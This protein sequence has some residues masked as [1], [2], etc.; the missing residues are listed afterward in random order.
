MFL[1]NPHGVVFGEDASVDTAGLV[2]STLGISDAD[3][4]AGNYRFEAGPDAGKVTNQ[5]S[6]EAGAGGVFLLAPNVENSGVIQ[7]DGGDLV[8][9]AGRAITLT[10]L[11]L[12][13]IQV[14]VQAPED[15]AVNLGTLLAERGAAG[16]FAGSIRNAGTVE[17][18]AVTLAEDGTVR[19]VFQDGLAL[20]AEER[21][22]A[23]VPASTT[24]NAGTV[25]LVAQGDLTLEAGGRV[26][27]DGL[28][29]RAGAR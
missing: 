7:T 3:F 23:G 24:R 4:Q 9:A 10:S 28:S 26:A 2:A 25:R 22:A 29:G 8:L 19:L 20:E 11:D 18:N 16:V 6:I 5:G 17:A 1:V 27:A 21:G 14:E 15:G 12:G 13:G